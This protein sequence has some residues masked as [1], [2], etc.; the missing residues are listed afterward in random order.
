MKFMNIKLQ[1]FFIIFLGFFMIFSYFWFRFIRTR[2]PREIPFNL[3]FLGMIILF[4]IIS[5]YI[6]SLI[7]IKKKIIINNQRENN[8]NIIVELFLFPLK[9][10]D[11]EI[12]KKINLE[13]KF[14]NFIPFFH[15]EKNEKKKGI[16]YFQVNVKKI[17]SLFF[18]F[19][20]LPCIIISLV[21]LIETFYFHYLSLLYKV[22]LLGIF[23][24]VE[25][26]FIYT[27]NKIKNDLLDQILNI[28]NL[29]SISMD[30]KYVV[31]MTKIY[32]EILH[33][34]YN[35]DEEDYVVFEEMMLVPL[36]QFLHYQEN[37]YIENQKFFDFWSHPNLKGI[38]KFCKDN[39]IPHN[40]IERTSIMNKLVADFMDLYEKDLNN[41]LKLSAFYI[42]YEKIM[43]STIIKKIKFLIILITLI[44]W[45]FILVIS[46][47]KLY[48]D[49]FFYSLWETSFK[50]NPFE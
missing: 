34:Y 32:P 13:E 12:K 1:R 8:F 14:I 37:Q 28:E 44:C 30:A 36:K 49:P 42:E 10:V 40:R 45:L 48:L 17:K 26:Y 24:L 29:L 9:E 46:L 43:R 7:Y 41:Y 4:F 22:I 16:E 23:I 18:I 25:K 27:I 47:P 6:Y 5:L 39:N 15:L 35:E 11:I 19:E 20:L 31:E 33:L 21:L 3:S 38:S 2:L 50:Q